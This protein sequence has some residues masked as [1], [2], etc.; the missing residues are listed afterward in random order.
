VAVALTLPG[1]GVRI[2]GVRD[3]ALSWHI[4]E[5]VFAMRGLRLVM[6]AGRKAPPGIKIAREVMRTNPHLDSVDALLLGA[7][8]LAAARA[9]EL[10]PPFLAATL[11]QESAFDPSA[12]SPAGAIGIAQFMVPTADEYGVD[13]WEPRDAIRGAAR[14]LS[15]YVARYRDHDDDPYA[16]ALAA[17][18]A[19]PGA[20]ARYQ[21]VPPYAETREYIVDVRDRW[22]RIVGR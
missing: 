12:I 14:L 13:P 18:D 1:S 6:D 17:Y 11:L 7:D 21:G 4:P 19:G 3:A 5:P 9:S 16:L 22:S 20:V 8:V 10:H 2:E 15:A